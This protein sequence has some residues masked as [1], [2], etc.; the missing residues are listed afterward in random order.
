MKALPLAI[1]LGLALVT[2]ASFAQDQAQDHEAHH[3]PQPAAPDQAQAA[4]HSGDAKPSP[5]LENRR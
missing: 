3:P 5:V 4:D 2:P 1:A